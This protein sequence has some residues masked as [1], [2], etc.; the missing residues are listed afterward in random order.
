MARLSPCALRCALSALL[1]TACSAPAD[2]A[3]PATVKDAWVRVPAPGQKVAAAYMELTSLTALAL[4]SVASPLAG[5]GE[6]HSMSVEGGVMRMR[7]LGKIELPAGRTVK[8]APGGLH[9]MLFDVRQPLKPGEKVPLVLTVQ[10]TDF[11]RVVFTI[12][13]EARAAAPGH[14]H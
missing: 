2:A 5:R 3:Q 8:L 10:R 6:L 7:P 11:S 13:A 14:G 12:E 4:V 1:V 9:V